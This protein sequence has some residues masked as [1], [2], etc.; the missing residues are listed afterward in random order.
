MKKYQ[1]RGGSGSATTL[2]A[3]P[4]IT[5]SNK[6]KSLK[7][8]VR[9]FKKNYQLTSYAMVFG[10]RTFFSKNLCFGENEFYLFCFNAILKDY[11]L[12]N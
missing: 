6:W 2:Q 1:R 8:N 5:N 12:F 10:Q 9:N 7:E 11:V 3:K 4:P